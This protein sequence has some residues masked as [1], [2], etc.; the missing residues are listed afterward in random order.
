MHLS[1]EEDSARGDR[2]E[3]RGASSAQAH[4]R[5]RPSGVTRGPL[6]LDDV[7]VVLGGRPIIRQVDLAV[8]TGEF[9][10]LLGSNGSGKSTLVRACVRLLPLAT[11]NISLF[12]T[13][14]E[15]F[16]AWERLGYVPQRS[17][18]TSGVPSTVGEV[19]TAG[20][21][22]HHRLF[23]W[24]TK[25]DRRAVDAALEL[26]E[27]GDRAREPVAQLSGGQQ[28]RVMIARALSGDPEL[29]IMDEPTAGVDQHSQEILATVL[30]EMLG[31]EKTVVMVAHELG[32][33]RSLVDRA[34]V[35]RDGRVAYDGAVPES[36]EHL[37]HAHHSHSSVV[38][39]DPAVP[40]EGVWL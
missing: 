8:E 9:V 4:D 35:L 18:A 24:P 3:E 10:T 34:V 7:G 2:P 29:L 21:L 22:A 27:L 17:T 1:G 37:G 20:R 25:R 33:F 16:H 30:R 19:V 23:G 5:A 6:T 26:V 15:R 38:H 39:D 32:P 40:P 12:G 14:I 36:S 31:Q 13:P 28:Q 11:G